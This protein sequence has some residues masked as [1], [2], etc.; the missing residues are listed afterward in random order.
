VQFLRATRSIERISYGNESGWLAGMAVCHSR[1]CIKTT[2]PILNLFRPFDRFWQYLGAIIEA[3][4][5]PS[6]IRNSNGNPFIRGTKYMGGGAGN[7]WQFSCDFWRISPFI[8][9]TVR[10]MPMVTMER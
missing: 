8:S 9:E 4:G 3:F 2:K 5:S 1:Y 10:D 6:A 7:N